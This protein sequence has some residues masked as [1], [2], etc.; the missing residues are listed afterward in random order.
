[1]VNWDSKSS[2]QCTSS[3]STVESSPN[4]HFTS[5]TWRPLRAGSKHT[6]S[7]TAIQ[8]SRLTNSHVQHSPFFLPSFHHPHPPSFLLMI[9]SLGTLQRL[10]SVP[11]ASC[12]LSLYN[13]SRGAA[14]SCISSS[15]T[16]SQ[17]VSN[18][19]GFEKK[20]LNV[21]KVKDSG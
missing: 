12:M 1:M 17:Q 16:S 19:K 18:H 8:Q 11:N 4:V 5:T 9:Q 3:G 13:Q 7:S 21:T 14:Q 10:G 2:Q 6:L 15:N 20:S